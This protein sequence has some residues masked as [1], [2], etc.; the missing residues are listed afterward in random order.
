MALVEHQH[1]FENSSRV[2]A[3]QLLVGMLHYGDMWASLF[4]PG[5][6]RKRSQIFHHVG[7]EVIRAPT[8][9]S[10]EQQRTHSTAAHFFH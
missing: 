2:I 5:A 6:A 7:T 10:L 1:D 9:R 3:N 8:N 4:W